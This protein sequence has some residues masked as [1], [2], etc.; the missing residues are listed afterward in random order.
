MNTLSL[1]ALVIKQYSLRLYRKLRGS[2]H[3]DGVVSSRIK[4]L[5]L[6]VTF[7]LQREAKESYLKRCIISLL[8]WVF[9]LAIYVQTRWFVSEKRK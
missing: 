8:A 7:V 3:N 4:W 6:R 2:N 1:H 9:F 5:Y